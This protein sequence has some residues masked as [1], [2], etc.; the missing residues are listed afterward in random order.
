M[1]RFL[2]LI[3]AYNEEKNIGKVI[4]KIKN[5]PF[6]VDIVVIDDGSKD[7]TAKVA[8]NAGAFVITLPFNL[9]YGSALQTGYKYAVKKD[10]DYLVQLDADG[11]HEIEDISELLDGVKSGK[12]DIVIGSRFLKDKKYDMSFF[13]RIGVFI[14]SKIVSI[15]IKQEI[16]DPVSG[17]EAFNKKALEFFILDIFPSD[18]PDADMLIISHFAGLKIKEIPVSMYN[19][20]LGKAPMHGGLTSFYYIFKMF[21]S[22]IMVL[23]TKKYRKKFI[24]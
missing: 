20:P 22:I 11:Q 6:S 1:N 2:L 17:F 15:I 8:E 19:S 18:F 3:P 21:L 12:A 10:Y 13:K 9:G 24:I 4:Y 14:F 23:I 7:N 16:T 5:L